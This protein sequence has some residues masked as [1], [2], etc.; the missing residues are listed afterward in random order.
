MTGASTTRDVDV[1]V[2]GAGVNGLVA[3]ARLARAGLSVQVLEGGSGREGLGGRQTIG[4]DGRRAS[5]CAEELAGLRSAIVSELELEQH[6][7]ET[8]ELP[9]LAQSTT[10][11]VLTV[12]DEGTN[13]DLLVEVLRDLDKMLLSPGGL[14][15]SARLALRPRTLGM[16][17]RPARD[18]VGDVFASECAESLGCGLALESSSLGPSESGTSLLLLCRLMGNDGAL[19]KS[20]V[21]ARTPESGVARSLERAARAS[22][23]V[24]RTG[25]GVRR[26]LSRGHEVVGVETRDGE[27][28]TARAT[29]STLDPRATLLGL[30]GAQSLPMAWVR[31][32]QRGLRYRG[33]MARLDLVV[34]DDLA[35]DIVADLAHPTVMVVHGSLDDIEAAH[36]PTR[37]GRCAKRPWL[38]SCWSLPG[39]GASE[40]SVL[41]V[42]AHG[43][44]FAALRELA[45]TR[46]EVA[47]EDQ[48]AGTVLTTLRDSWPQLEDGVLE[49]RL[50]TPLR[51]AEDF[52]MSEGHTLG[53]EIT[54]E[55][56]FGMRPFP[57]W[58]EQPLV[59]LELAGRGAQPGPGW[60]ALPG[61][62]GAGR[63]LAGAS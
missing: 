31:R 19:R 34:E 16:M 17:A 11:A 56:M 62:L 47:V 25:V 58:H 46:G 45:R 38:T 43:F 8:D 63:I 23:T 35:K 21:R 6:G 55:Q 10:G 13:A 41:S 9:L 53:T 57:E 50:Y 18:L 52:R 51:M 15:Q 5:F 3:A 44:P 48:V 36:R 22:G 4:G 40:H 20:S 29:V 39:K 42:K 7:L 61:W 37:H 54:I 59:G 60:T 33:C 26:I 12:E 14:A 32:L 49:S 27:V 28:V 1:V 24:I 2:V 30:V